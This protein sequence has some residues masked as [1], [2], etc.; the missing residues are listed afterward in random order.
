MTREKGIG[1]HSNIIDPHFGKNGD[2]QHIVKLQNPSGPSDIFNSNVIRDMDTA[3][4]MGEIEL[5]A[6][7]FKAFKLRNQF[8]T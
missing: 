4:N 2:G 6:I 8:E 5:D 7:S 3:Q 1:E